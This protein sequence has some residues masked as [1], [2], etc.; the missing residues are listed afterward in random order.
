M[1][2]N[3]DVMPQVIPYLYYEY[4][5][6]AIEFLVDGFGF[7][8]MSVRRGPDG[9]VLNAQVKMGGG[10]VFIGPGMELFGTAPVRDPELVSSRV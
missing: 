5:D 3:P 1:T 8:I 6:A 9:K 2:R 7:E 4:T 10:V